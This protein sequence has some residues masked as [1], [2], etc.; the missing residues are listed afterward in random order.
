MINVNDVNER[1]FEY[2]IN[3][4]RAKAKLLKGAKRDNHLDVELRSGCANMRFSNGSY[5]QLVLPLL[6]DWYQNLKSKIQ[7]DGTEVEILELEAG[8]ENQGQHID[9]KHIDTKLV[10][11][12]NNDRLVLHAYNGTQ[13]LMV[14]GKNYDKFAINCLEPFFRRKIQNDIE[15]ITQFNNGVKDALGGKKAIRSSKP[16]NCP[17]CG[18]KASTIGDLRMHMKRC[19][20]KPNIDTPRRKKAT[21]TLDE[22][23]SILDVSEAKMIDI[24]PVKAN[25]EEKVLKK[26][27]SDVLP[28]LPDIEDL[29]TCE[30]CDTELTDEK[31]LKEHMISIHSQG[32]EMKDPDNII[33]NQDIKTLE[34]LVESDDEKITSPQP[35]LIHS[36]SICGECGN[37]FENEEMCKEHMTSNHVRETKTT[38]VIEAPLSTTVS[39]DINEEGSLQV[40]PFCHLASKDLTQLKRHIENIH[41]ASNTSNTQDVIR[42]A[43]ADNCSV[44]ETCN[45]TGSVNEVN[46][47]IV[48]KHDNK[49]LVCEEC[50][51]E[52]L[53]NNTLVKHRETEHKS[54]P[55]LQEPFPCEYCGIVFGSFH[56]LQEH[57]T[58][59]HSGTV[60]ESCEHC[61]FR[62]KS[63]ETFQDHMIQEHKEVVI[64]HTIGSQ[65]DHLT[66]EFAHLKAGNNE[67]INLLKK[68]IENQEGMQKVL[69]NIQNKSKID[70]PNDSLRS[71]PNEGVVHDDIKMDTK[72]NKESYA[73][74]ASKNVE[75]KYFR[76]KEDVPNS[77]SPPKVLFV[78]DSHLNNVDARII[79]QE[80]NIMI[81]RAT[82][83]TADEDPDARYPKKNL[84]KVVPEKLI[85]KSYDTL[86]LQGG[87]NEISN[88]KIS[89]ESNAKNWEEKVRT[90]RTK[91]FKLAQSSLKNNSNLKKVIILK[92][93]PRY[94]GRV[95]DPNGVKSKLNQYGNT[96]YDTLWLENGCPK[97]IVIADQHLD[98]H[99]PL[100]EKR[101]GNPALKSFDG[102]PWDGVH[103]RGRLAKRHFTNSVLRILTEN[104]PSSDWSRDYHETCPQTLYQARQQQRNYRD[105]HI[106]Q[107][108]RGQGRQQQRNHRDDHIN[109]SQ[110]SLRSNIHGNSWQWNTATRYGGNYHY[111]QTQGTNTSTGQEYTS[112]NYGNYNVKVYN[113]FNHLGNY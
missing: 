6:R 63:K 66:D 18:V 61:S 7:L 58:A 85:N 20:T 56:L 91:I 27:D 25:D 81:E 12:A 75:S 48:T 37:R 60:G 14:Q 54:S 47:H 89:E 62:A 15:K 17:H 110:R 57:V 71:K 70:N 16:H 107:S 36:V 5:F 42:S 13:N 86:I 111:R 77:S 69:N 19:H 11:K 90:S 51:N 103:L 40:C 31:S 24:N 34:F 8:I 97:D 82:A 29:I 2:T 87:C 41:I 32:G 76:T 112:D 30:F 46:A 73:S 104:F 26:T 72:K 99:G 68:L 84:M 109:Q 52:F 59:V 53:D 9:T 80:T 94:E 38:V 78:G 50:G 105:Y 39:E 83:Y 113:R 22:D 44:C 43:G 55:I 100:R 98:C 95:A 101:Y 74:I 96:V 102:K 108:Q 93:I 3:K 4:K 92:S 33:E 21:I 88:I 28:L 67:L 1:A 49:V 23:M 79:E 10:V 65:V 35:Q 106:S 45:F 64:L